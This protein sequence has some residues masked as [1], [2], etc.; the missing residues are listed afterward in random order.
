ME[1]E[2]CTRSSSKHAAC[3]ISFVTDEVFTPLSWFF[4]KFCLTEDQAVNCDL[5]R[6]FLKVPQQQTKRQIIICSSEIPR[7]FSHS[8]VERFQFL[9]FLPE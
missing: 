8:E 7:E 5:N 2:G 4:G 9:A 6:S 1:Q 3:V